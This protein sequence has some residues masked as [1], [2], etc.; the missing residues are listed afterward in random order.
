MGSSIKRSY[1]I[2]TLTLLLEAFLFLTL[3]A[4]TILPFILIAYVLNKIC[5]LVVSCILRLLYGNKIILNETGYDSMFMY[6]CT[7]GKRMVLY[8]S[9]LEDRIDLRRH[10]SNYQNRVMR[11]K[12]YEKLKKI[13]IQKLGYYCLKEDTTFHINNH[14]RFYPGLEDP[15]KVVTEEELLS[16]IL[17]ELSCDMDESKPQWEEVIIPCYLPSEDQNES[18][19]MSRPKCVRIFRVHHGYMDGMSTTLMFTH[20]QSSGKDF[21]WIINPLEFNSNQPFLSKIAYYALFAA[22]FSSTIFKNLINPP[23]FMRNNWVNFNFSGRT[24]HAWSKRID[25]NVLKGIKD[26]TGASMPAILCSVMATAMRSFEI[27][28]NSSNPHCRGKVADEITIGLV[29]ALLPYPDL[30]LKNNHSLLKCNLNTRDITRM[31]RLRQVDEEIRRLSRSTEIYTNFVLPSLY[32]Q[33]PAFIS[34][35]CTSAIGAPA[36]VSNVPVSREKVKFWGNRVV[37]MAGW[38]PMIFPSG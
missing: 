25:M 37:D 36:C 32:G 11:E 14:V 7:N 38:V 29:G 1:L 19:I 18:G 5:R 26:N 28:F 15:C 6:K 8:L 13:W 9:V 16:I 22:T 27:K 31:E 30:Y 12:T 24:L 23:K 35:L 2:S 20:T 21:P 17:P 34:D 3:G 33:F 10:R 4:V